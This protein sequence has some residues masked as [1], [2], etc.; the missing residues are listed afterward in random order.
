[1]FLFMICLLYFISGIVCVFF[2]VPFIHI[3]RAIKRGHKIENISQVNWNSNENDL[4]DGTFKFISSRVFG[5]IIWPI[6][7]IHFFRN[8][9]KLMNK[10][11]H[12]EEKEES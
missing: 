3:L 11:T 1:M 5:L 10:Y 2:I 9:E 12:F 4:N 6:R 7:I 8:E